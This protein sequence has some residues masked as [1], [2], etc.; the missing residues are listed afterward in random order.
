[1]YAHLLNIDMLN[2][3][4]NFYK[5]IPVWIFTSI[6]CFCLTIS[7]CT[8]FA[9][10]QLSEEQNVAIGELLVM[11][12]DLVDRLDDTLVI[13]DRYQYGFV[14]INT[15]LGIPLEEAEKG[16]NQILENRNKTK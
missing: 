11:N 16:L 9:Q 5:S 6:L 8:N 15:A 14:F 12:N 1:M 2:K 4:A 7:V 13:A 3:C 10:Y